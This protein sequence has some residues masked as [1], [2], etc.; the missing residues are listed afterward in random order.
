MTIH[1]NAT[2]NAKDEFSLLQKLN[3]KV[4]NTKQI[5]ILR[6][7]CLVVFIW[8][9]S[10]L[11]YVKNT[12]VSVL[13][14]AVCINVFTIFWRKIIGKQFQKRQ[15]LYKRII[16]NIIITV[17][18]AVCLVII[19]ILIS[20]WFKDVTLSKIV[21]LIN[22]DLTFNQQSIFAHLFLAF[23][24]LGII[25]YIFILPH[26]LKR[27]FRK[28][29]NRDKLKPIEN[30]CIISI[31]LILLYLFLTTLGILNES[32]TGAL[33]FGIYVPAISEGL[34]LLLTV[35]TISFL[36][37]VLEVIE[38]FRVDGKTINDNS[39]FEQNN[40]KIGHYER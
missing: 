35:T 7:I 19:P 34:I 10:S 25:V 5:L 26:L 15:K 1:S 29:L 21:G 17:R 11:F 8:S 6:I 24:I 16:A 23:L 28:D 3:D 18:V 40:Q 36:S 22:D 4:S 37:L 31:L 2:Q 39:S 32:Q 9:L 38:K 30:S 13:I 14:F 27:L 20:I 33:L 12:T